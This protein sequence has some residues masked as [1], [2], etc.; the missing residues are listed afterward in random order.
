MCQKVTCGKCGK[1]TWR[2][3]GRHVD[4]VMRGI[5]TSQRCTGHE[6]ERGPIARFFGRN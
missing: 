6:R 1:P 5:P 2:G 4:E 3:C